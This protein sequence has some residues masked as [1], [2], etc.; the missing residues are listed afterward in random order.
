MLTIRRFCLAAFV[1]AGLMVSSQA[2]KAVDAR[3]LPANTE[4][5]ITFNLKQILNSDLAKQ[6]GEVLKQLRAAMDQAP[7]G[8]EVSK[9]LKMMGFD[10]FE[11]LHSISIAHPGSQDPKD[12][13]VIIEGAF[14]AKKFAATAKTAQENYPNEFKIGTIGNTSYYE[15]TVSGEVGYVALIGKSIVISAQKES[16][17]GA[18]KRAN[19]TVVAADKIR[20]LLKTTND[21]QSFSF[22]ITGAAINRLAENAPPGVQVPNQLADVRGITAAITLTKEIEFML[23][24]GVKDAKTAKDFENTGTFALAAA[25]LMV[26]QQAQQNPDL[27]VVSDIMRTLRLSSN[28]ANVMATGSITKENLEKLIKAAGKFRPGQ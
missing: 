5:V 12:L 19:G 14:D 25:K 22:A 16:L 24:V 4:I 6:N 8:D 2:I 28:G 27:V 11:D 15:L 20:D 26:N 3:L 7:N 13:F 21:K 1:A 17:E 10:P 9:Y 18:I 23:G